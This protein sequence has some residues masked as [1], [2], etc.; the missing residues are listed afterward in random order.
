VSGTGTYTIQPAL[1]LE[2][3]VNYTSAGFEIL[4]KC[5]N[6]AN[7]SPSQ[8]RERF[9]ELYRLD[10]GLK[11]HRNPDGKGYVQVRQLNQAALSSLN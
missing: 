3:V 1:S 5:Q 9:H 10:N 2:R 7:F 4:W 6:N 11:N 8:A